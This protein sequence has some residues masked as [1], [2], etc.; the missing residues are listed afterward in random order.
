MSEILADAFPGHQ[1]VSNRCGD[2]GY[3]SLIREFLK[4][5][6]GQV[7]GTG[8]ERTPRGKAVTDEVVGGIVNGDIGRVIHKWLGFQIRRIQ[9]PLEL[10]SDLIPRWTLIQMDGIGFHDIH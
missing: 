7:F 8:Q 5:S 3:S 6:T 2:I 1:H 10:L 9:R 4:N